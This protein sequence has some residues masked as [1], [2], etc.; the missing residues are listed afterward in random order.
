M[1]CF[2]EQVGK[3]YMTDEENTEVRVQYI[4]IKSKET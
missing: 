3:M 2:F 1:I 4:T